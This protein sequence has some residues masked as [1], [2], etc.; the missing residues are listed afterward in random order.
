M[1]SALD[2]GASVRRVM[3]ENGGL[4][5][6]TAPVLIWTQFEDS[7]DWVVFSPNSS[8]VHLINEAARRLWALASDGHATSVQDLAAALVMP[9]EAVTPEAL[10][11]TRDTLAFMD[12]AGL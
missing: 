10:N 7:T 12:D 8:E 11:L 4:S 3:S 6:W 5:R 2:Y 1:Q 9:G